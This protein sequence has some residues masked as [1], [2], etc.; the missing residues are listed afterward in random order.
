MQPFRQV[1]LLLLVHMWLSLRALASQ[2]VSADEYEQFSTDMQA[3]K[4][5]PPDRWADDNSHDV[6][7]C[8]TT[9]LGM[10][11]VQTYILYK[12]SLGRH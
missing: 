10:T 7:I 8:L 6:D 9:D 4:M 2:G 12:D 5:A 1:C 11:L 3:A